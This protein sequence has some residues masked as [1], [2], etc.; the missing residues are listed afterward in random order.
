VFDDVLDAFRDYPEDSAYQQR[1]AFEK[2]RRDGYRAAR[3]AARG[4]G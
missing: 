3:Q 4:D 2:M 1:L